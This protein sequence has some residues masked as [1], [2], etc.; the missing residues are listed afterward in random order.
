MKKYF[1]VIMLI[2]GFILITLGCGRAKSFEEVEGDLKCKICEKEERS[3]LDDKEKEKGY[4]I[5]CWEIKL[6]IEEEEKEEK[7]REEKIKAEKAKQEKSKKRCKDCKGE[8]VKGKAGQEELGICFNCQAHYCYLCGKH[9]SEEAFNDACDTCE[10]KMYCKQCGKGTSDVNEMHTD[11]NG[12]NICTACC[13]P[14]QGVC[15][16]C[17]KKATLVN[18]ICEMCHEKIMAQY[19]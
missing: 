12:D 18:G 3:V 5:S 4:C 19:Q 15:V 2:G 6:K 9:I 1:K 10:P 8:F 13:Q 17:R 16:G 7:V 11:I 14:R